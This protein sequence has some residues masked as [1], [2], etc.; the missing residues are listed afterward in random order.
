MTLNLDWSYHDFR[1]IREQP[2]QG[3]LM[4]KIKS[5]LQKFYG[6][7]Y[8]LVNRYRISVS[9]MTTDMFPSSKS[10]TSRTGRTAYHYGAPEIIPAF[11][12]VR[13]PQSVV[14]V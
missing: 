1:D 7:P 10:A 13:V 9:Q 4:A 5:S 14:P 11:C 6:R 12:E 3:F 8:V 2:N